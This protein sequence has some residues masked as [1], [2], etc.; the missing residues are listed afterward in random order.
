MAG[1]YLGE[2]LHVNLTTGKMEIESLQ[3]RLCR[4]FL[5][6]YG[7]GARIIF[8]RQRRG[9]SALGPDNHLGFA[10]GP[11][12]GT[13]LYSP[14]FTVVGKS[15]LTGT[16][17][18][19]NAGGSF[20]PMLRLAGYDAVFFTGIADKPIY[21]LIRD[22]EAELRDAAH[23]WGK[24]TYQT[25]DLLKAE[26]GKMASVACIGPSAEK[27]SLLSCVINDKGRA[28]ARSGLGAV[29]GAKKLKAVVALGN[30]IVPLADKEAVEQIRSQWLKK[31]RTHPSMQR[32]TKLGTSGNLAS[33]AAIGDAP[34]KNWAGVAARD[35]P[36]PIAI[37]ATFDEQKNP[38]YIQ[39][40]YTCWHCPVACGAHLK[41]GEGVYHYPAG[42]HRP[43]YESMAAFGSLCLNGNLES[44]IAAND[45]CNRYG[46]DTISTGATIA[47]AIECYQ[48]GLV[49]R[50]DTDGVELN[51]GDDRAI[52]AMTEKVA[53]REG[54]GDVLADGVRVAAER[55][56]QGA[57]E[58]AIHIGGQEVAMHD[59]RLRPGWATSYKID[60]T[61]GRHTQGGAHLVEG[62]GGS[63][64]LPVKPTQ[65][66]VYT[67]K[68]DA[69]RKMSSYVHILNCL[70]MCMF[71][72]NILDFD[73]LVQS[74]RAVTGWDC[75][76]EELLNTG[77][78][79]AT[80]RMAFN[81]R[82]GINPMAFD[83][84]GR[85]LGHP[86][87]PDGPTAGVTVDL[88]TQVNEYLQE[89]GWDPATSRPSK[90][91]LLELGLKDEAHVLWPE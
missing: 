26:W 47:F 22:S 78:R 69:Q 41:E 81:I 33:N 67:G 68:A 37:A 65:A 84:P 55:I 1:G 28:A 70:G 50:Q 44:I 63:H 7:L 54:F 87:L 57:K 71:N 17:G 31:I 60:A 83:V 88:D 29:M 39:R 18:D 23:L 79:I 56:G 72:S 11:L 21:L 42:V 40:P 46:L 86:P 49:T 16:W 15:P 80:M 89:M 12:T 14:R 4:E 9:A 59:P 5:G 32:F 34:V 19:A 62:R 85:I 52:V 75:T 20:G 30:K 43:E 8:T 3:E 27:L 74:L 90:K 66:F 51:W 24:D 73:V 61:P 48:N 36:N 13:P 53:R 6:G 91:S 45:I 35:Y 10:T 77:D 25:D 58:Y 2:V 64:G 82:E 76:A 38:K